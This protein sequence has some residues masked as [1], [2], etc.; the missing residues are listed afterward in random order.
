MQDENNKPI[1]NKVE[2]TE[3]ILF[4]DE[5]YGR[6][7]S[8]KKEPEPEVKPVI[9]ASTTRK[10][11]GVTPQKKR[12]SGLFS[13]QKPKKD[14]DTAEETEES[15]EERL[16]ED[17]NTAPDD[18]AAS[19]EDPAPVPDYTHI[20]E[21]QE[22]ENMPA[23]ENTVPVERTKNTAVFNLPNEE[24]SPD[25]EPVKPKKAAAKRG[26]SM[27]KYLIPLAAAL[28]L[29]A[30]VMGISMLFSKMNK[31]DNATASTTNEPV[32]ETALPVI[33]KTPIPAPTPTTDVETAKPEE[34]AEPTETMAPD[35][36]PEPTP[37]PVPTSTPDPT[38]T[39]AATPEPTQTP[40][41]TATPQETP[42]PTATPAPTPTVYQIGEGPQG[43]AGRIYFQ[44]GTSM[45]ANW[46]GANGG[47]G[48]T[49]TDGLMTLMTGA[50]SYTPAVGHTL[51]WCDEYG[52]AYTYQC[53]SI[54]TTY[55]Q[56][57]T[58]YV[59]DGNQLNWA[60]YGNMAIYS[61]GVVSY[62]NII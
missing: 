35:N 44:N 54:Y 62:W 56:D 8:I 50:P 38:P 9:N 2:E 19:F 23:Y 32:A 47:I 61:N 18:D 4:S 36:T 57:N 3:L 51:T 10:V 29:I 46:G 25:P 24:F 17:I 11:G 43:T 52:Y 5:N 49:R 15:T 48:V 16:N 14:T 60:T 59:S 28:A 7:S 33:E 45:T 37:T 27:N 22:P 58:V 40:A 13:R 55:V 53:T 31:H 26:R 30:I 41:A 39:P 1:I 6:S 20:A 21:Q 34:T 12:K 42:K